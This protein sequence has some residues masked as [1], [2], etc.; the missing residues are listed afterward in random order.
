MHDSKIDRLQNLRAW[1][2]PVA[3]F[4]VLNPTITARD[5]SNYFGNRRI[6][7][8]SSKMHDNQV[9][10]L[11]MKLLVTP[12][13]VINFQ[14]QNPRL[15]V[16]AY[17]WV[18]PNLAKLSGNFL[19]NP[20][21]SGRVEAFEGPGIVRDIEKKS[22]E[23]MVIIDFSWPTQIQNGRAQEAYDQGHDITMF[24]NKP[25]ILEFSCYDQS[26]VIFWEY[27]FP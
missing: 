1:G 8:R 13:E 14:K 20:D 12:Y 11:P 3:D 5:I 9:F 7:F 2:F 21:G 23:E 15:T 10:N 22:K 19:F 17:E 16:F 27:R 24:T 4:M 6:C 26:G 25:T 18:D